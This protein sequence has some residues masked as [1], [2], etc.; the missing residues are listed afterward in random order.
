MTGK[1]QHWIDFLRG[2]AMLGILLFHTEVYYAGTDIIPYDWYVSNALVIF[3]FLSGYLL[4][5]Q[6]SFC[7]Y[8]LIRSVGRSLLFPYFVFTIAM[9]FPKALVHGNATDVVSLLRP[10]LMGE[11]SWFVAALAV[12]ET[13][14]GVLLWITRGKP[15]YLCILSTLVFVVSIVF[16]A[17]LSTYPWVM[18]NALLSVLFLCAGWL[19]HRYE[20]FFNI[21]NRPLSS[22]SL[23]ILLIGIKVYASCQH[24]HTV[25]YPIVVDSY[26]TF[27]LDAFVGILF[28]VSVC[29][30]LPVCHAVEWIG[31][32]SIVFYFLCGGIPLCVALVLQKAHMAYQNHYYRVVIAFMLVC[33]ISCVVV[34]LI[35]RYLPVVTG[36]RR[37]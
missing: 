18:D 22:F 27:L 12:A 4:F 19:Y 3:F 34:G 16:A 33:F 13:I 5:R 37:G 6:E 26:A 25:V 14:F 35:Y 32:R 31:V 29:R 28:L 30:Q 9:A 24:L 7:F 21:F 20:S 10:I 1:R 2:I 17:Q 15:F 36:R 23:F 8:R 11:A